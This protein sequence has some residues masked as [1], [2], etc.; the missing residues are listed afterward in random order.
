MS[1]FHFFIDGEFF[2]A[3]EWMSLVDLCKY[4]FM[5]KKIN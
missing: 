4:F 5:K 3:A 1:Y 2:P